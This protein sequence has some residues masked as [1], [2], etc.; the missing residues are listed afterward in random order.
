MNIAGP[1]KRRSGISIQA[2]EGGGINS[3]CIQCSDHLERG[4][5]EKDHLVYPL[6]VGSDRD[7]FKTQN[8]GNKWRTDIWSFAFE[9]GPESLFFFVGM[10]WSK[11]APCISA[12]FR[13][14]LDQKSWRSDL[15]TGQETREKCARIYENCRGTCVE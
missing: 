14:Y 7:F 12:A 2:E 1:F 13:F 9:Q 5:R 6:C 3:N 11:M 4:G 15:S 8:L 10:I